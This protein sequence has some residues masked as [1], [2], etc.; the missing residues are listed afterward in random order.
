VIENALSAGRELLTEPEAKAV[1]AAYGIPI[2]ETRIASNPDDVAR[3]AGQ[4]GQQVALKVISESITHKS[5]VGG[6]VLDIDSPEKAREA[7]VQ[8]TERVAKLRP[9]AIISGFTVQPMARRPG[10]HELIVGAMTD[11]IFGPALLFGEGGTAVEIIADKAVALPPLNAKL[12]RELV[13][14]TRVA[15]RLA[16]YRDKP[17]A[18]LEAVYRTLMQVSQLICDVPEIVELDV[19]P[20][21]TDEH[22][23]LALDARLRVRVADTSGTDR[24][25]IR[26]YPKELEEWVEVG[27]AA[28]LL[29]PI[30]PE[31]EPRHRAFLDKCDSTDIR[32]RFFGLVRRF[33]HTQLARF[34]QIDYNR[35][36]AFVATRGSNE[37]DMETVGVVRAVA[38]PDNERAE[39]A[40]IISSDLKG[41][42]LGRALLEKMI[43]YCRERGTG[44]LIGEILP[45]NAVMLGLAKHLGFE[46]HR[47]AEGAISVRLVLRAEVATPA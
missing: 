34:T 1:L 46:S 8:M 38:D 6:V 35:E 41:Q 37:A 21:V 44:E 40:I 26:P 42:G 39:F 29:R 25:A 4:I 15:A 7:A 28:L 22:G 14:R 11:P 43:R 33:S 31:D 47:S 36:M 13:Q 27:G 10:A 45:E 19:N 2:V 17:P 5:D 12:A 16:G 20:L 18:D 9:D 24:L 30:R 3:I 32:F 23:V